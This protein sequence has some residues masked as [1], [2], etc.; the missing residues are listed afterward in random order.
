MHI[1]K[2]PNFSELNQLMQ[3]FGNVI[4]CCNLKQGWRLFIVIGCA[5]DPVVLILHG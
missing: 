4:S 1:F 3:P 2:S 5:K